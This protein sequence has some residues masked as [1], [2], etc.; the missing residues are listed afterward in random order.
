MVC[1]YFNHSLFFSWVCSLVDELENSFSFRGRSGYNSEVSE[2]ENSSR[3][4]S[5]EGSREESS[6][7]SEFSKKERKL[8]EGDISFNF[9]DKFIKFTH[10]KRA[11]MFIKPFY[12]GRLFDSDEN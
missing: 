2:R 11:G 8:I 5:R 10:N 4:S 6:R 12:L 9:D 7:T 1:L 3:E